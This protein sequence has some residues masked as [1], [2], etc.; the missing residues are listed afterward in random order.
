MYNDPY[1]NPYPN[2]GQ[3]QPPQNPYGNPYPDG[4][5]RQSPQNPYQQ[6]PT[7]YN[8]P[9]YPPYNAGQPQE[10][11]YPG[12][13]QPP[14]KSLKWLWI[15]LSIVGAVLILSCS[16]CGFV[17]YRIGQSAQT[18]T[19]QF[20]KSFVPLLVVNEYYQSIESQQ[21]SKAY[22][23]LDQNI[24]TTTGSPITVDAFTNSAKAIDSQKGTVTTFV[25][26]GTPGL[27]STGKQ[28]TF[29]VQVT[30]G[31]SAPYTATISLKLESGTWKI[32]SYDTI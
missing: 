31:S 20:G 6:P 32:V 1:G 7:Q 27:D 10:P 16:I 3:G 17:A 28:A 23:Y 15:T 30:R 19:G 26:S 4:G 24:Q 25:A 14:K 2:G 5:Q 9:Q 18:V 12:F 29:T 11:Y 22:S 21:Y 13:Q 8:A